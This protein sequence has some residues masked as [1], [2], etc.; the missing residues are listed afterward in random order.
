MWVPSIY[1][2]ARVQIIDINGLLRTFCFSRRRLPTTE[3]RLGKTDIFQDEKAN[4]HRHS[5]TGGESAAER[6]EWLQNVEHMCQ[7]QGIEFRA[8]MTVD[9]HGNPAY[10]FVF[11]SDG[12]YT[13]FIFNVFGDLEKPAGH[14]EAY[15]FG[16]EGQSFR[17]A[18]HLAAKS[19]LTA[20]GIN[21]QLR[22]EPS[23]TEFLFDRFLDRVI[24]KSLLE[25]GVIH[26]SAKGLASVRDLVERIRNRHIK[27]DSP[28]FDI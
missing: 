17:K 3:G 13:D 7:A 10:E 19:H 24:F 25:Q 28:T 26:A 5:F 1:S 9:E 27:A 18:F 20:L 8:K 16:T 11:A 21:Y 14:I 15:E 23:T 22:E 6:E 4:R 12:T 2:I